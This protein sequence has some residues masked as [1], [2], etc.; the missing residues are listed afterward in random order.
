MNYSLKRF[1]KAHPAVLLLLSY[2]A[3]ISLGT[4][5]LLIPCATASGKIDFID[6]L[7]T[8]TSALCVTGLVVV[9]T[10][11][12]FTLFGQAIILVLIQ[13]GGLGIMAFSVFFFL[14]IGKKVAFRHRMLM[15][16]TFAHTPR[17][18][19]YG[20]VKAIFCFTAI[21]ELS[22]ASLLFI[23]WSSE[24]PF[25]QALYMA[26]FHSVS[27]FCNAGFSLL[28]NSF[29]DYRGSCLLNITICGLI[30]LGGIGFPVIYEIF[31]KVGTHIEDRLKFSVQSKTVLITTFIL[32]IYGTVIFWMVEQDASLRNCS[33]RESLL[34]A[35][36]QSV[37]ARTAGFNTVDMAALSNATLGLMIFLMFI[38]ASPGSC[39][40]GVKTTTLAVLGSLVWIRL[41]RRIRVNM[42][43]KSIPRETVTRSV[44]LFVLA[45]GFLAAFFAMLLLTQQGGLASEA[46]RGQFLEYLFELVSAFGTVGLSM[47]AT[48][49][50]NWCGKILIIAMMLIGRV[51]VL[52][53]SYVIAGAEV[54]N[55]IEYAE[56]NIMIG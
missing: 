28:S 2:L 34:A 18:D 26:I 5:L 6:A 43:K 30:I 3:A 17:E 49:K 29:M 44:S 42:F 56:E 19:I 41:H 40:G 46:N 52:T 33:L 22:G 39:G 50:I 9:D 47:G 16:E 37:T 8:A 4:C 1:R 14:S 32:I 23:H 53:F 54:R 15:Q 48:A 10:G 7:F 36:F 38:G 13:L 27:A 51:G 31:R 25:T 55:G 12:Y 21:V 11:S 20:L 35:L 45:I 24:Y